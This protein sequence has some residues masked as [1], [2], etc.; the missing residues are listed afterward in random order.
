M[1]KWHIK[2]DRCCWS[3]TAE[4]ILELGTMKIKLLI[5]MILHQCASGYLKPDHPK[6]KH[7]SN[8]AR[9][10]NMAKD[11]LQGEFDE[12]IILNLTTLKGPNESSYQSLELQGICGM[13]LKMLGNTLKN[14]H[15]QNKDVDLFRLTSISTVVLKTL[16]W[17]QCMW[18]LMFTALIDR[19]S[20]LLCHCNCSTL[21][22]VCFLVLTTS[23][24][25]R[26]SSS[27]R[28]LYGP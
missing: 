18:E 13:Y 9:F 15:W 14:R 27:T 5:L 24:K 22:F 28:E 4:V 20:N 17:R 8:M 21:F 19:A 23:D 3:D 10:F 16:K 26:V 12:K 11:C 2:G 6:W 1:P 7:K 25:S